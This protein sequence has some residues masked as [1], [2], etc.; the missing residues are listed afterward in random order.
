MER[1]FVSKFVLK[2]NNIKNAIKMNNSLKTRKYLKT[3]KLFP[4]T[5][6]NPIGLKFSGLS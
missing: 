2:Y 6:L 4:K 1:I 5:A 3:L